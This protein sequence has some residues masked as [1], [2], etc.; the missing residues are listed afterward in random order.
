MNN[1]NKNEKIE[2]K[3]VDAFFNTLGES[4]LD[5]DGINA[6][7]NDDD[8]GITK[9]QNNDSQYENY[10]FLYNVYHDTRSMLP[11]KY[12][13]IPA[14]VKSIDNVKSKIDKRLEEMK[15]EKDSTKG[16]KFS[17]SVSEK[18]EKSLGM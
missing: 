15:S 10:R 13:S 9:L 16:S 8:V 14:L 4:E 11:L 7:I 18:K 12:E 3:I 6:I 5:Q 1:D 2:E 17:S